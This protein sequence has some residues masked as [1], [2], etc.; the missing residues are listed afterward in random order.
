MIRGVGREG[1]TAWERGG[2]SEGAMSEKEEREIEKDGMFLLSLRR[3][4]KS[5]R[6]SAF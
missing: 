1:G 2:D 4:R 5:C 3:Q 6:V